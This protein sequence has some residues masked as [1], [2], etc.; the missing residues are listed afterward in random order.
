MKKLPLKARIKPQDILSAAACVG[1]IGTGV[2]SYIAGKRSEKKKSWVHF[3]LPVVCGAGTVTAV[4]LSHRAARFELA[5]LAATAGYLATQRDALSKSVKGGLGEAVSLQERTTGMD[6]P[7]AEWTGKGDQLCLEAYSGRWFYSSEEEVNK[8]IETF[9]KGYKEMGACPLNDLY[10]CLG[11][12][13][14][15]FGWN[16]GWTMSDGWSPDDIG[17]RTFHLTIDKRDV[18]CLEFEEFCY[19]M[20]CWW[21]V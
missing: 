11:I 2:T 4:I 19:P 17:I 1:V 14:T 18:L 12:V 9:R 3:I 13:E 15:Q 10:N 7:A 5:G 20:E 16:T 21:E 6:I 8:A